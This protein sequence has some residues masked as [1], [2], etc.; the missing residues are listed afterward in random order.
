MKHLSTNR[1]GQKPSSN[2]EL[3]IDIIRDLIIAYM[4][5]DDVGKQLLADKIT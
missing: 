5:N 3:E 2:N 4:T 1:L